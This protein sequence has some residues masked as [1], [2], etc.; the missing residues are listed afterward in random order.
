LE[1]GFG[2]SGLH[3]INKEDNHKRNESY[4]YPSLRIGYRYHS[5]ENGLFFRT[6]F[7]PALPGLEFSDGYVWYGSA[8]IFGQRFMPWAGISIGKTF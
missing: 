6:T 7:T 1:L 4:L 8:A 2:I 3:L 5:M